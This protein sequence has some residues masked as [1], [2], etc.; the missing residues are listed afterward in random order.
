ML[1][2][3]GDECVDGGGLCVLKEREK[4]GKGRE[5]RWCQ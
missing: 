4:E 5:K 2:L 3:D 1:F